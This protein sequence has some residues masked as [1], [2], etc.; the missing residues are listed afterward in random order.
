MPQ[1]TIGQALR[2]AMRHHQAGELSQM[3]GIYRQVLAPLHNRPHACIDAMMW[4][5]KA[6]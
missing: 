4:R 3:E 2:V 6:G 1:K 5:E